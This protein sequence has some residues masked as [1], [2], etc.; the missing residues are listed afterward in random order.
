RWTVTSEPTRPDRTR[1]NGISADGKSGIPS[2][3][4]K[5]LDMA[6]EFAAFNL[7]RRVGQLFGVGLYSREAAHAPAFSRPVGQ[8]MSR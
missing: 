1:R 5:L 4:L 3:G 6:R 8:A 7:P 2:S